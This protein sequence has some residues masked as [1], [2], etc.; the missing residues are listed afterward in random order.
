MID[1]SLSHKLH[2]KA[3]RLQAESYRVTAQACKA[4]GDLEGEA[5]YNLHAIQYD[6]FAETYEGLAKPEASDESP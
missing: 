1:Y 2:A 6:G 3:R 4:E 5:F